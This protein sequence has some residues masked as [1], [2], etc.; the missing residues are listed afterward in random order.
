MFDSDD[1][2]LAMLAPAQVMS[3][4]EDGELVGAGAG[5][6][7]GGRRVCPDSESLGGDGTVSKS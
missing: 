2:G 5:P 3:P 7:A 4:R 1:V 6:S